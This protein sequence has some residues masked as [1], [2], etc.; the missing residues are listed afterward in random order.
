M[1]R[2]SSVDLWRRLP[3][4]VDFVLTLAAVLLMLA[5][6]V[7]LLHT[8]WTDWQD[9]SLYWKGI[10]YTRAASPG[11]YWLHLST[12]LVGG[13]ATGGVGI[14]CLIKMPRRIED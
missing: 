11:P 2:F 6:S 9:Q 10:T 14:W 7:H 3:R 8:V 4:P 12:S 1:V 5:L 13:L